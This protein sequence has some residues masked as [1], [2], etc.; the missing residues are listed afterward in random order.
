MSAHNNNGGTHTGRS[1]S[2]P[3]FRF[4]DFPVIRLNTGTIGR[5]RAESDST[6]VILC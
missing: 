5:V 1:V 3:E 2:L 4:L 6:E